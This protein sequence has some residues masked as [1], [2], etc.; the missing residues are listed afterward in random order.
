SKQASFSSLYSKIGSSACL[1][2]QAT[3]MYFTTGVSAI[4]ALRVLEG[5]TPGYIFLHSRTRR[6]MIAFGDLDIFRQSL[7][8]VLIYVGQ[9]LHRRYPTKFRRLSQPKMRQ[10]FLLALWPQIQD[11]T[12]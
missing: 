12:S 9:P 5:G 6:L 2:F 4:V 3:F 10:R 8:A 11:L 1:C 7:P